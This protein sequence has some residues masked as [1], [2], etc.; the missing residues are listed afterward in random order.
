MMNLNEI[1]KKIESRQDCNK[2]ILSILMD[3]VEKYPELRF[4]QILSILNLDN[5]GFYI[6]SCDTLEYL[7]N[8]VNNCSFKFI[9]TNNG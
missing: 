6:E 5:D 9:K 4:Q 1:K 3:I 7:K 2:E 8:R